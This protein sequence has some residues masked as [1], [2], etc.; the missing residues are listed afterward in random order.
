[1]FRKKAFWIV[2]G[3]VIVV[4]VITVANL[5]RSGEKT[6]DVRLAKARKATL[7]EKVKAPGKVNPETIV[8]ISAYVS[9]RITELAVKEGDWVEKGQF[10]FQIDDTQYRALVDQ[11]RAALSS[12]QATLRLAEAQ[13]DQTK[14]QLD[15]NEAMFQRALISPEQ[16]ETI[17]TQA[18]VNR[19]EVEARKEEAARVR[20]ALAAARDNLDKT[21]F[22]API[23]G[24]VSQLNVEVGEIVITGTMNNPGTV[25]LSIAEL[26]KMEVEADV[27]ETD[28][29]DV[30][31]GQP[32]TIK[33]DAFPDTSFAGTVTRVGSSAKAA[34]LGT[35][36]QEINYEVEVVFQEQNEALKPGMT[37]DVEIEVARKVDAIAIPIQAVVARSQSALD[38]DRKAKEMKKT[39]RP[40]KGDALA[41]TTETGGVKEDPL[42]EGVFVKRGDEAVFV[43]VETGI[44]SDTEIEVL[45]GIQA[46]DELVTGPFKTLTSIRDG[47]KVKPEKK[48]AEEPAK[49]K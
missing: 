33:V 36:Q 48:G 7:V 9:G 4:A 15:R 16:L 20:A 28:V 40:K 35:A 31:T 14:L 30:K 23:A 41:D 24:I 17:R 1:M 22:T 3:G 27:D 18:N 6:F 34:S 8:N 37:A 21:R 45:S 43:P 2:L 25:I 46:G 11:S 38:R 5:K 26:T 42:I 44:S 13:Y 49:K 47:A 19:A 12:A 29:V 10:L 39:K 32:A